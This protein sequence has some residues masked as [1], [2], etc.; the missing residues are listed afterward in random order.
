MPILINIVVSTAILVAGMNVPAHWFNVSNY[1]HSVPKFGTAFTTL[2]GTNTLST[3]PTTYNA[4]LV[5]TPNLTT[6]N[7]FTGKGTFA[8][9]VFTNLFATSSLI[10][11][12]TLT[13]PLGVAYNGTGTTSPTTNQVILG[14]GSNG[15]K[16]IGFGTTGQF[17]TSNGTGSA[18][19]WTTSAIDQSLAYTW[20]GL[21]IFNTAGLISNASSTFSTRLNVAASDTSTN[22]LCLR[23]N[24]YAF[25]IT[26]TASGTSLMTDGAGNL[27]FNFAT[28]TYAAGIMTATSSSIGSLSQNEVQTVG[29]APQFIRLNYYVQG[30]TNSAGSNVFTGQRGTALFLGTTLVYNDIK[31]QNTAGL[32]GGD[33]GSPAVADFNNAATAQST[34]AI[35]SGTGNNSGWITSALSITNITS[36]GFTI[37]CAFTGNGGNTGRCNASWEAWR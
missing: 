13:N 28:S 18:P 15:F 22:G 16:V 37:Q 25:P 7:T 14:N 23:G 10:D 29:F 8:T 1:F 12:L 21:H 26:A 32:S 34:T 2:A 17:F 33:N 3:F 20:T 19:S 31:Y 5:L 6:D 27:S 30:H 11:T 4:N 24:C 36:T 35:S 9:G